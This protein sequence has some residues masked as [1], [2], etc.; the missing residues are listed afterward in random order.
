MG[1][2]TVS[3]NGEPLLKDGIPETIK[4]DLRPD[5]PGR[6]PL[7]PASGVDSCGQEAVP[8]VDVG[9]YVHPEPF[10]REN[11]SCRGLDETD[12]S[13]KEMLENGMSARQIAKELGKSHSTINQRIY[14]I[15]RLDFATNPEFNMVPG[16]FSDDTISVVKE[17]K[18][19]EC[20]SQYLIWPERVSKGD[21]PTQFIGLS[22]AGQIL[23]TLLPTDKIVE[24]VSSEYGKRVRRI[25][26]VVERERWQAVELQNGNIIYTSPLAQLVPGMRAKFKKGQMWA[27]TIHGFS[28]KNIAIV[29]S[30]ADIEIIGYPDQDLYTDL[31]IDITKPGINMEHP[32]REMLEAIAKGKIDYERAIEGVSPTYVGDNDVK[33]IIMYAECVFDSD[34]AKD[35]AVP[36]CIRARSGE[37]KTALLKGLKAGL[38]FPDPYKKNDLTPAGRGMIKND[39][40]VVGE[41]GKR[42]ALDELNKWDTDYI[43]ALLPLVGGE[44]ETRTRLGVKFQIPG[45]AWCISTLLI[46]EDYGG[47]KYANKRSTLVQF[48]R[49]CIQLDVSATQPAERV[50]ISE[51]ISDSVSTIYTKIRG[52]TPDQENCVRELKK[53]RLK[54]KMNRELMKNERMNYIFGNNATEKSEIRKWLTE[55]CGHYTINFFGTEANWSPEMERLIRLLA[56]G[57]TFAHSAK[58]IVLSVDDLNALYDPNDVKTGKINPEHVVIEFDDIKYIAEKLEKH[59]KKLGYWLTDQ[60]L[61]GRE[62]ERIQKQ[63]QSQPA[64]EPEPE[65]TTFDE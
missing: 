47:D 34:F 6:P 23:A 49:R 36:I 44:S 32:T 56:A 39:E 35:S 27:T 33:E 43:D 52:L 11:K 53:V 25:V 7:R 48:M 18:M 2:G 10:S 38:D 15:K 37:G 24:L 30:T 5:V 64:T 55:H 58:T 61:L 26:N 42:V 17:V 4:S 51:L 62:A 12:I 8:S 45:D 29:K 14:K 65:Q 41:S 21:Q 1:E 60:Q 54:A 19:M 57:R 9:G 40:L 22:D 20:P 31:G 46:L 13:I 63:N 16:I 59:A 28:M 3:D 50:A